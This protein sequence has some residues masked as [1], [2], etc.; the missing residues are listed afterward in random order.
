MKKYDEIISMENTCVAFGSFDG[1]H[2]G[3]LKIVEETVAQAK[4]KGLASVV[5]SCPADG[6]VMTTEREKEYLLKDTGIDVLITCK[7]KD[8]LKAALGKLGAKVLVI[9]GNHKDI[10]AVKKTAE[11]AGV[12]VVVCEVEKE[13]GEAIT[14]EL[15]QKAFDACDFEK[16]SALCGHPYTMIGGVMHGKALGRTVGMPTAN[17]G[18]A[19]DK[20]KPPSGV[21][22]TRLWVDGEKFKS[23]TNIGKR[24]SVDDFDYVTIEAFILDFSRDIYGKEVVMEVYKFVRGV[25][26]FNNLEE[27]QKQVAKDIQAVRE[28]PEDK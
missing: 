23:L 28:F 5:I 13:D 8:A 26:K 9:G 1:V 20:L 14:S 10:D 6:S 3:H 24:P 21:Y 22:A 16:V 7:E 12:E 4:K 25:Q 2:K 15:I 27:V 11:E 17:L 19:D 18:V